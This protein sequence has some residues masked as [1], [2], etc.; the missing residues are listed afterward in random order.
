MDLKKILKDNN[1][2]ITSQRIYLLELINCLNINATIKN[3]LK[4]L[5]IDKS[6]IYRIIDLFIEKNILE[7]NI[8]HNNEIYYS[9]KKGHVH[10][11]NCVKCHKKEKLDICP[12]DELEKQGYKV[13]NHKIEIEGICKNCL[14]N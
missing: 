10:Y 7:K 2:K 8:N 5:D 13:I 3:I 9:I 14:K 4:K 12:I 6:T 11:I 1:L